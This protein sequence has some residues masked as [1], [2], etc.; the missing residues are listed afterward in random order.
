MARMG[1][2]ATQVH[3]DARVAPCGMRG[4]G[5][6]VKGPRVS[7]PGEIIG[8]V[9]QMRYAPLCFID[10]FSSLFLHVG[11]CSRVIF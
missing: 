11:L 7:G 1:G 5:W 4:G 6:Q 8:A 10:D 3:A 9:A 2:R